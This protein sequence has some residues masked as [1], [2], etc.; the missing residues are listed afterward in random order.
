MVILVAP[1]EGEFWPFS[2][3]PMFSQ[4]GNIWTRALVVEYEAVPDSA[5]WQTVDVDSLPGPLFPLQDIAVNQ[6]DIAN[7]V[8][9]NRDWGE[10][11]MR[12]LVKLFGDSLATHDLMVL[13]VS[14]VVTPQSV[15][16]EAQPYLLITADSVLRNPGITYPTR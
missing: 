3:F 11:R 6:N 2:I 14:P 1:H 7:F 5:R 15:R 12:S 4:G 10:R 9:K 16:L 8:Q 13:R